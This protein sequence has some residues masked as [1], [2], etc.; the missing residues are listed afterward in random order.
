MAIPP[1]DMVLWNKFLAWAPCTATSLNLWWMIRPR[2]GPPTALTTFFVFPNETGYRG[3]NL[4]FFVKTRLTYEKWQ[5]PRTIFFPIL[6]HFE[7]KFRVQFLWLNTP[8]LYFFDF[9]FS[10]FFSFLNLFPKAPMFYASEVYIHCQISTVQNTSTKLCIVIGHMKGNIFVYH[11]IDVYRT[12]HAPDWKTCTFRNRQNQLW[13]SYKTVVLHP[14][15]EY[16]CHVGHSLSPL[17]FYF[18]AHAPDI[19]FRLT[20]VF[21]NDGLFKPKSSNYFAF[22]FCCCL[23]SF[24]SDRKH[25]LP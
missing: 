16:S 11:R 19:N 4:C 20:F 12:A 10:S 17:T 22:F 1:S 21:G 23:R 8:N 3:E 24:P 18:T 7:L 2:M 25:P 15:E 5:P 9:W 6:G 13:R 14:Y